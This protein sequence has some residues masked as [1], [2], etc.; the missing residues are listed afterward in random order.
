LPFV[1]GVFLALFG[2]GFSDRPAG[3]LIALAAFG[4]ALFIGIAWWNAHTARTIQD[5]I[6]ALDAS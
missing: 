6:D 1:P 5:E 3:Q 2:G 4:V